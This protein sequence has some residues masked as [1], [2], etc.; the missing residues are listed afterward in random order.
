MSLT[1]FYT[2]A[3]RARAVAHRQVE[4][5]ESRQRALALRRKNEQATWDLVQLL[6]FTWQ[7]G[8]ARPRYQ[9][10]SVW[11]RG[12]AALHI[13]LSQPVQLPGKGQPVRAAGDWLCMASLD[14]ETGEVRYEPEPERELWHCD[15][16]GGASAM[17][18]PAP[19]CKNCLK[20]AQAFAAARS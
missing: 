7:V 4:A 19:T 16:T 5:E 13:Q 3:D 1:G 14:T 6:P 8:R 2:E 9:G 18:R 11:E 20:K 12:P 15:G 10:P 17:Y